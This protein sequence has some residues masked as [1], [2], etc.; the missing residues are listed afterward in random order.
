MVMTSIVDE[1][2]PKVYAHKCDECG[3]EVH[4]RG[5]RFPEKKVWEVSGSDQREKSE[6]PLLNK[7]YRC[8]GCDLLFSTSNGP[9]NCPRCGRPK[10]RGHGTFDDKPRCPPHEW[11]ADGE[12]CMECGQK[13][14]M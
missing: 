3:V 2:Y 6:M 14:W 13:D 10:I 11:D 1:E 7:K 9:G 12:R 5:E 4:I 8:A